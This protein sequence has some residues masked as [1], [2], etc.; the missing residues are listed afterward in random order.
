M[1]DEL[2]ELQAGEGLEH[3][4]IKPTHWRRWRLAPKGCWCS[5]VARI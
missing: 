2:T 4:S 3:R 1:R 5:T